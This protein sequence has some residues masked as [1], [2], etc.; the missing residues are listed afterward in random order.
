MTGFLVATFQITDP[1]AYAPYV[2]A[3]MATLK[4]HGAEVIVADYATQVLEGAPG[5]VTVVLKF[6]SKAAAK[7]WYDSPEYRSIINLRT[8]NSVKTTVVLV[9]QRSPPS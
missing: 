9:D 6:A 5:D 7:A 8:A 3:V 4:A 1:E 2:P